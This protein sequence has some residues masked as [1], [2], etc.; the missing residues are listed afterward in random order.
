MVAAAADQVQSTNNT[1][2]L[3]EQEKHF[4]LPS[5]RYSCTHDV[6]DITSSFAW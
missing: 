4:Y 5:L 3:K 1:K 6:H 2:T